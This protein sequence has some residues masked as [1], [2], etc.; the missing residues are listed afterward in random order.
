MKDIFEGL[1]SEQTKAVTEIVDIER[2]FETTIDNVMLR[3]RIDRIDKDGSEFT[4][5]DYKTSKKASSVNEI[6]KDTPLLVYSLVVKELYGKKLLKVGDWFLRPN[7][8]VFFE[9]Q[10][11]A[12]DA[13]R[14]E[15][16]DI[17]GK[18]KAGMFERTPG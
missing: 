2:W 4:V 10:D 15:I 11:Q 9:P 14:A 6:K 1:N 12:I 8:K 5:I 17:A 16:T 3:G 13:L 18:I 7:E